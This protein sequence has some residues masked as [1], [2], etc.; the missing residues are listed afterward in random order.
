MK[1]EE[2]RRINSNATPNG[3]HVRLKKLERTNQGISYVVSY[4][5]INKRVLAI[6]KSIVS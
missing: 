2:F 1:T 4:S 6:S 3:G 5:S